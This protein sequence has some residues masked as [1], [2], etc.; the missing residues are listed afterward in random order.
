MAHPA[1]SVKL[2]TNHY[3][4]IQFSYVQ[5]YS[6]SSIHNSHDLPEVALKA[7]ID[8]DTD[9]ERELSISTANRLFYSHQLRRRQIVNNNF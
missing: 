6:T 8:P 9:V 2:K 5:K 1:V 7:D 3:A 4:C